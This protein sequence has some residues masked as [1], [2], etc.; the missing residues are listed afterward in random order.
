MRYAIYFTPE[1]DDPLTWIAANWLGRDPYS[2][3]A[4][5]APGTVCL[6]PAEIAYHTAAPRRYGF[7]ATL[8]A[9]FRLGEK[10]NEA[11][12]NRA[13]ETFAENV[14]PV[15]IPRLAL[16][17]ID[18]FFALVPE[19]PLP[20]LNRFAGD[21]VLAF[22]P[23][24]A[25]LTEAEV[26]RRDPDSLSPAEFRNLLQWGYPHVFDAFRFHMTLTGRVTPQESPR[27][28]AAIEEFFGAMLDEPVNVDR[29]ALFVEPEPGAPFTVQ[30]CHRLGS[31][32]ERKT[33]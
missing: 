11:S 4:R 7:H 8:K 5:N 17:Q 22:E 32:Q 25:P 33:A 15:A 30:S 23:F 26:E 2:G 27:V 28:R 29:L 3:E 13:L 16:R 20:A 18:N 12:L 10:E 24:R 19:V 31:R 6:S 21:V 9:P 1:R 14:A